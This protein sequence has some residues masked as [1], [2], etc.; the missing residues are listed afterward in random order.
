MWPSGVVRHQYRA[1]GKR[2]QEDRV[3]LPPLLKIGR[4]WSPGSQHSRPPE[5]APGPRKGLPQHDFGHRRQRKCPRAGWA[6]A[7][8]TTETRATW[9][10]APPAGVPRLA[11]HGRAKLFNCRTILGSAVRS[12]ASVKTVVRSLPSLASGSTAPKRAFQARKLPIHGY[13]RPLRWCAFLLR[14]TAMFTCRLGPP[15]AGFRQSGVAWRPRPAARGAKDR[16]HQAGRVPVRASM[17]RARSVPGGLALRG[18]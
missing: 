16:Q 12:N 9:A 11:N 13:L 10:L 14:T 5:P 18:P 17:P 6:D 4:T 7:G 3:H 1:Q 2:S 15:A 8:A